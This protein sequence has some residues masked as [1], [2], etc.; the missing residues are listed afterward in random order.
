MAQVF[1]TPAALIMQLYPEDGQLGTFI[2]SQNEANP[3]PV[4]ERVELGG[5]YYCETVMAERRQLHV[6]NALDDPL[7]NTNPDLELGLL[8]YLGVPL[9]WP[10]GSVF[11]TICVLDTRVRDF[12]ATY[13]ELIWQFKAIVESDLHFCAELRRRA[14]MEEE[15]R[16]A[17]EAAESANR[18]KSTFLASMSHE[19]RTPMNAILGFVQLMQRHSGLDAELSKDLGIVRRS[20]EHLLSLINNVLDL[21]KIEVGRLTMSTSSFDLWRLLDEVEELFQFRASDK[22][23][24]LLVERAPDVPRFI[25][26]DE[27]RLRQ[28]LINLLGN[29]LKFTDEGSVALR[30]STAGA[31]GQAAGQRGEVRNLHVAVEDT[32]PGIAPDEQERI[33]EAFTQAAS[34]QSHEGTG[35]GLALS[36]RFVRLLGGELTLSSEVGQGSVFRFT[37]PVTVASASESPPECKPYRVVGLEPD[38]PTYRILVVD[39]RWSN[40]HLLTRLLA[41]LGFAVQ[42][43]SNGQEAIALWQSWQPHLIWMD[44]R[45]PMMDGYE[46]TRQIKRSTSGQATAIIALTASTLEEEQAVVLSAGCDDFVRKP[47]AEN[48]IFATMHRHIGVR[49]VYETPANDAP[50]VHQA[51]PDPLTPAAL[52]VLP[53]LLLTDLEQALTTTAPDLIDQCIAEVCQHNSGIAHSL[54][55]LAEDF[56]Y[57]RML[58]LVQAARKQ[59]TL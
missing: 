16:Q 57:A 21:S 2:C 59:Q 29:A 5:G 36:R 58:A 34:A 23:L 54:T 48:D 26:S 18:A 12:S 42:E 44:M 52:A 9:F 32:G 40:R 43:A 49:Y 24:R 7:W 13:K 55:A 39:D 19:L 11:G 1:D 20:G 3:Y 56:E 10:D 30:V 35:L 27:T 22:H 51:R 38:Q 47:F 33:F 8:C 15:L 50:A 31:T 53:S 17:K 4:D 41:P 46:A 25:E 14:Q 45:M 37:L 28:V 6:P